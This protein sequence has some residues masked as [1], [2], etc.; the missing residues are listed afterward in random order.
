MLHYGDADV[1]KDIAFTLQHITAIPGIV[2]D[3]IEYEDGK[4]IKLAK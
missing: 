4:I 3:L 2:D 1:E